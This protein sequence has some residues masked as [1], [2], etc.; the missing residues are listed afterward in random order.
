M[1]RWMNTYASKQGSSCSSSR[2]LLIFY[3]CDL[4]VPPLN[5]DLLFPPLT[6][7]QL[8]TD[9]LMT[10]WCDSLH[11][12][13]RH[14]A[15]GLPITHPTPSICGP[16]WISWQTRVPYPFQFQWKGHWPSD[17]FS[18]WSSVSLFWPQV[19][20]LSTRH[21]INLSSCLTCSGHKIHL[22]SCLTCSGPTISRGMLSPSIGMHWHWCTWSHQ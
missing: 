18:I 19:D 13:G 2:Y 8:M 21:K 16:F 12:S 6:S 10:G 20:L 7:L 11:S 9:A 17:D 15:S 4:T 3:G 22:S 1:I 5:S 14:M